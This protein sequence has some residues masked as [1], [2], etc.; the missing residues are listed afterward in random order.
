MIF[1]IIKRIA[2]LA[3]LLMPWASTAG[4]ECSA[5]G[6]NI[7]IGDERFFTPKFSGRLA[8]LR[9][10]PDSKIY[11]VLDECNEIYV[12]GPR[13]TLNFTINNV[14]VPKEADGT[15]SYAA[16][17]VAKIQAIKQGDVSV[18]LERTDGWTRDGE[19]QPGF[20]PVGV[21][22]ITPD[23]FFDIHRADKFDDSA[24]KYKSWWW[25]ATP[26]GGTAASSDDPTKWIWNASVF[27][28]Q[29][30]RLLL[31]NRLYRFSYADKGANS[32]IPFYVQVNRTEAVYI[33]YFAPIWADEPQTYVIK[34]R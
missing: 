30:D 31:S 11:Y 10:G 13:T 14:F 2:T 19:K 29:S 21:K 25:H 7:Q 28:D 17:Q 15:A 33:R 20:G 26:L 6:S 22:K 18:T 23:R 5:I 1:P 4:A 34:I 12:D 32:G 27:G 16:V 8:Y 3:V 9:D 24:L